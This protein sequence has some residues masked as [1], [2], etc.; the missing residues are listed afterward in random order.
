VV[1]ISDQYVFQSGAQ[2]GLEPE[3]DPFEEAYVPPCQHGADSPGIATPGDWEAVLRRHRVTPHFAGLRRQAFPHR[4]RSSGRWRSSVVPGRSDKRAV[5]PTMTHRHAERP[6]SSR[7]SVTAILPIMK[8]VTPSMAV[9]VASAVCRKSDSS[10]LP[11]GVRDRSGHRR[12]AHEHGSS[13]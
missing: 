3:A 7:A 8:S 11:D 6:G 10:A 1:R 4:C 13:C 2:G 5:E 12:R 9:N